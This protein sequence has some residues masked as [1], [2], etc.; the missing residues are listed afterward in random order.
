MDSLGRV[1]VSLGRGG[2]YIKTTHRQL[3]DRKS[4]SATGFLPT[5]ELKEPREMRRE[6]LEGGGWVKMATF[7]SDSSSQHSGLVRPGMGTTVA[8]AIK[9]SLP[10]NQFDERINKIFRSILSLH[11]YRSV[12]VDECGTGAFIGTGVLLEHGLVLTRRGRTSRFD[13]VKI[14]LSVGI[15]V[16]ARVTFLHEAVDFALVEYNTADVPHGLDLEPVSLSK[17]RLEEGDKIYFASF[18]NAEKVPVVVHTYVELISHRTFYGHDDG[19]EPYLPFHHETVLLNSQLSK[20]ES[21]V[22]IYDD[23]TVAGLQQVWRSHATGQNYFLPSSRVDVVFELWRSGQLSHVRFQDF[24][25]RSISQ[26]DAYWQSLPGPTLFAVAE[27][28]SRNQLLVVDRVPLHCTALNGEPELHPLRKGDIILE[29]NNEKVTQSSDLRY[30]F[31]DARIP[32]RVLRDGG[33]VDVLVPTMQINDAQI[34]EFVYLCGATIHKPSLRTRFRSTRHSEV[35]VADITASSP[36]ELYELSYDKFVDRVDGKEIATM[37]DFKSAIAAPDREYFTLRTLDFNAEEE[38]SLKK[39][40]D[41]FPSFICSIDGC[42]VTRTAVRCVE[43]A[44]SD[45]DSQE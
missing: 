33:W 21:G 30:I 43:N 9:K 38:V 29:L 1:L 20:L 13:E 7:P 35:Y 11:F 45:D 12:D 31:T 36:A 18:E 4:V 14:T 25:V 10:E 41:F 28:S 34:T 22:I 6:P 8:Q 2:Q 5:E 40:E 44:D 16:L 19:A 23:G 39:Y 32:V 17:R 15:E 37:E 42:N 27:Q 26:R 24:D 3:R